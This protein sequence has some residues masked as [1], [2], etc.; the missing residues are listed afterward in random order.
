[1]NLFRWVA[2]A[3]VLGT[4]V[5]AAPRVSFAQ[6][7]AAPPAEAS[8]TAPEGHNAEATAGGESAGHKAV[9]GVF[10]P[11]HPT[12]FNLAARKLLGFMYTPAEKAE[13]AAAPTEL[14]EV[15]E[16][17]ARGEK[18]SDEETMLLKGGAPHYIAK[19]DWL[20]FTPLVWGALLLVMVGAAKKSSVRPEGKATSA[21]NTV[22][23]LVESFQDYLVGVMG[24]ELA[25]K[26]M[27]LIASFFFTILVSN[28]LGLIPGMMSIT[29]IPAVPIALAIVAF[30]CVHIIAIKEAGFKSYIMHYVGEPLWLAPLLFPLHVIG[31]FIKPL[32]LSMRLLCNVFGEEAVVVTLSGLA[33]LYLPVWLPIPF[34]LPMLFLGTFFGFLQALVFSTLLSIYLSIFA[35]HH[36]DHD[37]HNDHGHVEHTHSHGHS[38]I[39]A[40][41][42]ETTVA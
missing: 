32:S 1:M 42:S 22:E 29:A 5:F 24:E 31:E 8:A 23:W 9:H 20:L 14:A 33:L 39:V 26:Y 7:N 27:P 4:A 13:D 6:E 21:A 12:L 2:L 40:H 38:V 36:D 15:R 16:K 34:Q 18:L 3:A 19:Y 25:R 35:T 11:E 30:F 28:W 37:A 17:A 41:P 10:D